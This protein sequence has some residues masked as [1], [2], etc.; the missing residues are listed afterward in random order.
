MSSKYFRRPDES[1]GSETSGSEDEEEEESASLSNDLSNIEISHTGSHESIAI[2]KNGGALGRDLLIHALL[3]ERCLNQV[4]SEWNGREEGAI[5]QEAQR[6]YQLLCQHLA[7]LNL[8]SAG[9][10]GGEHGANRQWVRDGLD[11]LPLTGNPSTSRAL[12][13]G[14][15]TPVPGPLRRYLTDG[16]ASPISRNGIFSP[17]SPFRGSMQLY[18]P[19]TP[20]YAS[21]FE[22]IGLLGKGGYGEVYRAKHRVDGQVYAVKRVPMD[23]V[24]IRRTQDDGPDGEAAVDEILKE[25]R[26]LSRLSHPNIVRYNSS[27]V[28]MSPTSSFQPP[29]SSPD[30]DS[31]AVLGTTPPLS[32]GA[33]ALDRIKTQTDT[34]EDMGPGIA[35]DSGSR[36]VT[37]GRVSNNHLL[38]NTNDHISESYVTTSENASRNDRQLS[39][40]GPTVALYVQMAE[41]PMTLADFISPKK[42]T[43]VQPLAHCFHF[44]PSIQILL[45]ILEGVEYMHAQKVVHRDLK[46]ANVF[47][48]VEDN[49]KPNPSCIDLSSCADCRAQ[50]VTGP[51]NLS[52]CIGDFGLV[53][54]ITQT[55]DQDVSPQRAV[56]TEIYRPATSN[57]NFSP[58][59]DIFAVGVIACELLCKFDTQMERRHTLHELRHGKYPKHFASCAGQHASRMRECVSSML[60][61]DSDGH[62]V[63]ELKDMLSSMLVSEEPAMKVVAKE[64][65]VRSSST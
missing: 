52:V 53:T 63:G 24:K 22:H 11:R 59:L 38:K 44:E 37:G 62:T 46:P 41:Y 60:S 56:G 49:P 35:F 16:G 7:P 29:S 33:V 17:A 40:P 1:S 28:E 5:R 39:I 25:V 2:D 26:S 58:R 32:F 13:R 36:E 18:E 57:D 12:Q 43:E 30:T 10:E 64:E 15:R 65:V 9:L 51:A 34:T 31:D 8:F 3:E 48:K 42:K 21:D 54:N 55:G 23:P 4:R 20:R 19:Q 14:Q 6:R 45:A 47:L 50:K 61:D 27:W